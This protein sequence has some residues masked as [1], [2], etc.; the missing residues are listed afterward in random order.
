MEAKELT[1]PQTMEFECSEAMTVANTDM[2]MLH[3]LQHE[4]EAL[5][6]DFTAA[7]FSCEDSFLSGKFSAYAHILYTIREDL[8]DEWEQLQ[9]LD[10][11]D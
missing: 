9:S 10:N 7:R 3:V 8:K 11:E 6:D 5:E 4:A 2:D 1:M